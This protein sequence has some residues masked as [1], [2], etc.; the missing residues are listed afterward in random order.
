MEER[1]RAA[2]APLEPDVSA[3][4]AAFCHGGAG[5]SHTV[6]SNKEQRILNAFNAARRQPARA[7][8]LVDD[9][10]VAL[11]HAGLIAHPDGPSED[12]TRLRRALTRTG[13]H[14]SEDGFLHAGAGIDVSS[15]GRPAIDD[16]LERLRR[17]TD[18]AALLLGVAKE[19]LESVAKFAL[20]ELEWPVI[21]G[22]YDELWHIARER[23]G[24]LPQQVDPNLA[25]AKPIKAIYQSMWTIA[26]QVNELR[27][28]QGTGHGRTLPSGVS[29]DVALYVAREACSVA[30]FMLSTLERAHGR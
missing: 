28:L 23:L 20:E 3:A 12:E 8:G 24:V 19:L 17:G 4:L 2:A 27:N 5:P 18:D 14:L 29:E 15:G 26:Q 22:S 21:P 30:E 13:W 1:M 6:I 25:G 9:L 16:H 10:L 7:R 11:R